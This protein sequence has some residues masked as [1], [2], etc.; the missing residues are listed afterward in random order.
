MN[1]VPKI[2][3]LREQREKCGLTRFALSKKIGMGGS[4]LYRIEAGISPSVH[5]L[6]AKAIADALGCQ[7]EDI[8]TIPSHTGQKAASNK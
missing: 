2:S 5:G 4:A 6:T 1:Y 8:F 3:R 7:V